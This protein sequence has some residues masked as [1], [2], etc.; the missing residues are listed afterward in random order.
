MT[1]T[2]VKCAYTGA[3]GG[4]TNTYT[5]QNTKHKKGFNVNILHVQ[6]QFVNFIIEHRSVNLNKTLYNVPTELDDYPTLS[7]IISFHANVKIQYV[8]MTSHHKQEQEH[9]LR[10]SH[11]TNSTHMW[12]THLIVDI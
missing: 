4:L 3:I 9:R 8:D 10:H 11:T 5:S 7:S 6:E 12:V 2:P 1:T